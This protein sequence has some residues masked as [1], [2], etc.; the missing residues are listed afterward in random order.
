MNTGFH[1]DGTRWTCR[2]NLDATNG[3]TATERLPQAGEASIVVSPP[4]GGTCTVELSCSSTADL[5]AGN[6]L[7]VLAEGLGPAGVVSALTIDT[8]PSTI[9]AIR[10]TASA[11]GARVEIAQ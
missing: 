5:V 7:F 6:G 3:L 8:I 10:V 9:T 1:F 2:L 4:S 11:P